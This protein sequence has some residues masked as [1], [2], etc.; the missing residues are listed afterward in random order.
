MMPLDPQIVWILDN[1]RRRRLRRADPDVRPTRRR[2]DAR[3]I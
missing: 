2:R 1:D 3:R